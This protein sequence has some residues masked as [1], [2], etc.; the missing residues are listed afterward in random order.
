MKTRIK[1]KVK[2]NANETLTYSACHPISPPRH[3]QNKRPHSTPHHRQ[4]VAPRHTKMRSFPPALVLG[5]KLSPHQTPPGDRPVTL[6]DGNP[7]RQALR[8]PTS[9]LRSQQVWHR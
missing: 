8:D 9:T 5:N 6:V 4:L 1:T 3:S 2:P 7:R